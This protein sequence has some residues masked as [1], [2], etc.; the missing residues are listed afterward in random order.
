MIGSLFSGIGGLELGLEMAGLGPVAWQCEQDPWCRKV[1]AKHWPDATRYEDVRTLSN[2]PAVDVMCGGFPCQDLT[3][4]SRGRRAEGLN[5]ER[6]GLWRHYRRLIGVI[7]P[8][9]VVVENVAP[10]WRSWLPTVRRD[11]WALG[12][13]SLSARVC[14]ADVGAPHIRPRVLVVA[15]PHSDREPVGPVDA[16]VAW[17][18]ATAR[19]GREDWGAPSPR[20][21]GVADGVADAVDRTH[22]VG[23]AVVPQVGLVAGLVV[24]QLMGAA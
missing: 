12:Y 1:L 5:G 11:L 3:T 23:N 16:Q 22:A 21:L 24:R 9:F 19:A 10:R 17:M 2:P 7:R 13:A 18:Q 15:Y 20:A 4:A 8:A 6:S 14:A